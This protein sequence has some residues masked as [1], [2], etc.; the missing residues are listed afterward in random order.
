MESSGV[1]EPFSSEASRPALKMGHHRT[2]AGVQR[3]DVAKPL[4]DGA[5]RANRERPQILQKRHER[6][7]EATVILAALFVV[8]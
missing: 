7:G 5:G 3:H 1:G 2:G 8:R 6:S 4:A